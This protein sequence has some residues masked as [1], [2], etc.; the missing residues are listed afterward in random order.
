MVKLTIFFIMA[1][2]LSLMASGRIVNFAETNRINDIL[3]TKNK[4]LALSGGGIHTIDT[5]TGESHSQY[6]TIDFPDPDLTASCVDDDGNIWIGSSN[7]YLAT[8]DPEKLLWRNQTNSYQTAGWKITTLIPYGQYL[9]VGSGSGLSLFDRKEKRAMKNAVSFNTL[10]STQVNALAIVKDRLYVGLDGGVVYLDSISTGLKKY[11]FFNPAIWTI[12]TSR[13]GAVKS[14]VIV[15]DTLSAYSQLCVLHNGMLVHVVENKLMNG[16][17][18]LQE[19][20][21]NITSLKVS[22][23]DCWIGT[24]KNHFYKYNS[25]GLQRYTIQG[26]AF[27]AVNAL[28]AGKNGHVLVVPNGSMAGGQWWR[29]LSEYTGR[30]WIIH[31]VSSSSEMGPMPENPETKAIIRSRE[32][33]I[34]IATAGAHCKRYTL[35]EN[36]WSQYCTYSQGGSQGLSSSGPVCPAHSWAKCDAIAQDSSGFIWVGCWE[37]PDG[38]LICF[39]PANKPNPDAHGTPQAHY[40]RFFEN[41]NQNYADEANYFHVDIYGTIFVGNRRPGNLMIMQHDGNPIRDG[42][43]VVKTFYGTEMKDAVSVAS[44]NTYILVNGKLNEY[45]PLS[46]TLEVMESVGSGITALEY[47]D[48]HIIWYATSDGL[49]RYDLADREPLNTYGKIDGLIS[50]SISDLS[51]DKEYGYMWIATDQGV[52]RLSIGTKLQPTVKDEVT[53]FPVPF[54]KNRNKTINFHYVSPGAQIGIYSVKGSLVGKPVLIFQNSYQAQFSWT[55]P[56]RVSPGTYYY[57]VKDTD[58]SVRGR[59]L[60]TP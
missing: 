46:K 59:L 16:E 37:N 57:V 36:S 48:E 11:N 6:G 5:K 20:P 44:G 40:R 14:F 32:G 33:D 35:N 28:V 58:S 4:L 45:D 34:W 7:G 43:K 17:N 23:T 12:D 9:F 38:S 24:R 10:I 53:V 3:I 1:L 55:V 50:T 29:G 2:S 42:V 22:G 25:D 54:R 60:I 39:D 18:V 19:F 52:S 30:S 56:E 41:G 27:G 51:L 21:S 31:N 8:W 47:E 26:P 15:N 49:V 13:V